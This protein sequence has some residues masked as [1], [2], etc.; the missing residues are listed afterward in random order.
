MS[1]DLFAGVAVRDL[2][3]AVDWYDCLFG[4]VQTFE[5]DDTEH[6]WTLSP[7]CHVYAEHRPE[8][9]GHAMLTVFVEDIDAFTAAAAERGIYPEHE[10][11]Y[12]NGVRKHTY[13]DPDGNEIGIGGAPTGA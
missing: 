6:V 4:E 11:T 3:R 2:A 9:A 7:H 1:L 8:Q 13:H 10:V 5:P 12:D